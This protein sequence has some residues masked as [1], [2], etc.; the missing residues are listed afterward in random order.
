MEPQPDV[1][2]TLLFAHL[3]KN[4]GKSSFKCVPRWQSWEVDTDPSSNH[5]FSSGLQGM[6]REAN[7]Q[8]YPVAPSGAPSACSSN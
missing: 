2:L 4:E 8:A 3:G 1:S 6:Q 5:S 7:T